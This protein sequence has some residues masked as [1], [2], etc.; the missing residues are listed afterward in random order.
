M[1]QPTD[2][3]QGEADYGRRADIRHIL[4]QMRQNPIVL[5]GAVISAISVL[6]ALFSWVFIGPSYWI[7]LDP[8]L[9]LCWN[10][11]VIDWHIQN[12]ITSCGS[13]VFPLGTDNYGRGLLQMILISIPVD[14]QIA[15]EV[16]ASAV[17]IGTVLGG[18]AAYLGGVVDEV[19]LRVTDIFLAVPGILLAIVLMVILGR[20]IPIL[21][22]S[23]LITWW[24][25]YVRLARSQVLSEKEKLYVE[26]LR[27]T[28][29]GGSRILF[30]H[31]IPNTIYPVLVQATLD[32]GAVILTVSALMFIGLTPDPKYPE[33]GN[34]AKQGIQYIFTA[35]W[36]IVFPGLTLLII[37]VGFNLLGDGI[38]DVFDPRLRR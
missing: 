20:T 6:V 31:I 9:K 28:G 16:V 10:N 8:P 5:A 7:Q 30:R 38:R 25:F 22:I 17:V 2:G 32:I 34:L 19:I 4:S 23:V 26:R 36:L 27:A 14:L 1:S 15:F 3:K 18:V 11:A 21:T 29:V 24:P 35:P 33:L 37:S 12:A 13:T